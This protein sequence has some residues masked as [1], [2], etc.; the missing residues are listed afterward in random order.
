MA[1][2]GAEPSLGHRF[3]R[4]TYVKGRIS[5]QVGASTIIP[6]LL[7]PDIIQCCHSDGDYGAGR[8]RLFLDRRQPLDRRRWL[9]FITE[10][11]KATL[12]R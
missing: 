2:C 8:R 9:H 10:R 11:E 4:T 7:L 12:A 5:D 3:T 6:H 1:D